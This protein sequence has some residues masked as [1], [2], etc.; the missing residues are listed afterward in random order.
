MSCWILEVTTNVHLSS[1]C[2]VC[3]NEPSKLQAICDSVI[4]VTSTSTRRESSTG[5]TVLVIFTNNLKGYSKCIR[6]C[7]HLEYVKTADGSSAFGSVTLKHHR[8]HRPI[9]QHRAKHLLF[10][11]LYYY[12]FKNSI[13]SE[14]GRK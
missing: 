1:R 7:S 5:F 9:W 6:C 13:V 14:V 11:V 4:K 2:H 3:N 8:N 10:L 12:C